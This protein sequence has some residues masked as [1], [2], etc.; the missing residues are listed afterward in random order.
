MLSKENIDKIA[1]L[2]KV[3]PKTL[4]EAIKSEKETKVDIPDLS[5]F[6]QEDLKTRDQNIQKQ[7]YDSGKAVGVE[8]LVKEL[9]EKHG[10]EL[11]GK[12]PHKFIEALK[13]KIEKDANIKPDE[14]VNELSGV[15]EKL[16]V[17]VSTLQA[18]NDTL[19]SDI[20]TKDMTSKALS[21]VTK[22][23]LLSKNDM[24]SVMKLN[25]YSIEE[26]NGSIVA[27]LNGEI[28]RDNMT[29]APVSID[30]VFD[31]YAA[32]KGW[33]KGTEDPRKGRGSYSTKNNL[34]VP[35]SLSEFE[36][37]WTG[38]G[39][40]TNSAEYLAKAQEYAKDNKDFFNN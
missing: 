16:K 18:E 17:N 14:K 8:I 3:D 1:G 20:R 25:G 37:Q 27:K 30:K 32:E 7:H 12:D 29:Q 2:I 40:S 6:T 33:A 9:K 22:D 10:I 34:G 4:E 5:V 35:S 19:K 28:V 31:T 39:K 26:E 24:L 21:M 13:A 11:E 23:Y 36:K 15:I 38:E